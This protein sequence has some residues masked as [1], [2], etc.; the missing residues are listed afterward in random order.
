MFR[1]ERANSEHDA[2]ICDTA[3]NRIGSA[4]T[5]GRD[6]TD[7]D[8][9]ERDEIPGT[10]MLQTA[11]RDA[12]A[13]MQN[14]LTQRKGRGEVGV[15]TP[16]RPEGSEFQTNDSHSNASLPSRGQ[17]EYD[18]GRYLQIHLGGGIP[19]EC[20]VGEIRDAAAAADQQRDPDGSTSQED[21]GHGD[22]RGQSGRPKLRDGVLKEH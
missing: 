5:I 4:T 6:K 1:R 18:H 2:D 12:N 10:L 14:K 20:P 19:E 8:K 3:T 16:T 21:D 13:E 22:G 11:G 9:A 7:R 15:S 17:A